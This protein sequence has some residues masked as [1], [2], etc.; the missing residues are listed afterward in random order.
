MQFD[1]FPER[2]SVEP[3]DPKMAAGARTR[4]TAMFVVRYERERGVH[5]VFV[6]HHGMYCGEHG[7]ACRAVKEVGRRRQGR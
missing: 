5:Q 6:D 1:L 2:V 7:R 3:L 4:I